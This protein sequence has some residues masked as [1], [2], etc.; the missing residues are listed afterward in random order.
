MSLED[1]EKRPNRWWMLVCVA[2]LVSLLG[3]SHEV[4]FSGPR[5]PQ[6]GTGPLQ[7]RTLAVVIADPA[8]KRVY[9]TGTDG[10]DYTFW[11]L[12]LFLEGMHLS[13]LK[14]SGAVVRVLSH[15]PAPGTFDLVLYPRIVSLEMSG[16]FGHVCTVTYSVTVKDRAGQT[17]AEKQIAGESKF[18]PMAVGAEAC[19]NA[20]G[21]AFAVATSQAL[22]SKP[23]QPKGATP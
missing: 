13:G 14:G 19:G 9:R 4:L 22:G 11:N 20:M 21:Y 17:V 8:V 16:M 23:P 10:H 12:G 3:C 18:I 2:A 7:G 5:I 6:I 1:R 15:E